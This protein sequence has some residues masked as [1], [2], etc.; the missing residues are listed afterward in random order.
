MSFAASL[1]TLYPDMFPASLGKS[2][3]GKALEKGT[4]SLDVHNIRD[5]ATDRH[6][7]VDGT[8]AG[9]GPGMV[10]KADVLSAAIAAAS[11]PGD[12]RPRMLMSPRG[13][14]LTQS[15]ARSLAQNDGIVIVCGR[16]EGVDERVIGACNLK[17]VS[18]GDYVLS[19]G[20]PAAVVVLDAI[21]RLLP[22]VMG[23]QASGDDESHEHGLLEHPHYTRPRVWQG[24]EIPPV[25]LSGNHGEIANWRQRQAR[26]LTAA[27]R[28]ELSG[29]NMP[30]EQQKN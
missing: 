18:I 9:G 8:P 23:K 25:L 15:M 19:G 24:R 28:P 26:D 10:L 4:W 29:S 20:E 14:L 16:F 7:C 3:A 17:E 21:I 22:G 1:V 27:R 11:P 12:S 5:Y 13:E 2:L 6:K 30:P